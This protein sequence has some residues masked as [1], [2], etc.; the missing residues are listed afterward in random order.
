M[1]DKFKNFVE[2]ASESVETARESVAELK[3]SASSNLKFAVRSVQDSSEKAWGTHSEKGQGLKSVIPTAASSF[4]FSDF[5]DWFTK[6]YSDVAKSYLGAQSTIYDKALDQKYIEEKMGGF[7]HRLFDEGHGLFDAWERVKAANPDDTLLQEVVGY[8][9]ALTQD[10]VTKMGLPFKTIDQASFD[11]LVQKLS[12]IP[13]F[14]KAYLYDLLSLN[15]AELT[16]TTLGVMGVVLAFK[17]EDFDQLSEILGQMG[18]A[19]IVSAN[20]LLGVI[21]ICAGA[22][23]F[24]KQKLSTEK[25]AVGS[26]LALASFAVFSVLGFPLLVEFGL[27]LAI[28]VALKKG[29]LENEEVRG[30][31]REKVSQ[32]GS[33]ELI[34][35]VRMVASKRVAEISSIWERAQGA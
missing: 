11:T 31:F 12:A 28:A 17:S 21:V 1:K 5:A 29:L 13:G 27:V 15:A 3:D 30:Y 19:A 16:A 24:K 32:V 22:F 20:P 14:D 25:V 26:T 4:A 33:A 10:L 34:D 9:S 2:R 23:A 8:T 6:S 18:V 7:Y 35:A